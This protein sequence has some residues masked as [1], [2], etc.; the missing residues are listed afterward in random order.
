MPEVDIGHRSQAVDALLCDSVRFGATHDLASGLTHELEVFRQIC[1]LDDMRI[2][3]QNFV[4]NGPRAPA[5][6]THR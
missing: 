1:A 2:G 3:V 4:Q 5:V 6:F